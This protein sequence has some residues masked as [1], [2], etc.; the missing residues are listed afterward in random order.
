MEVPCADPHMEL[1][2]VASHMITF[3]SVSEIGIFI[4]IPKTWGFL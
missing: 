3:D 2:C 1:P 4:E